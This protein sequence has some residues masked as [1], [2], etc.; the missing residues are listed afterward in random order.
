MIGAGKS[1]K[2]IAEELSI[3]YFTVKNHVNNLFIKLGMH[4]RAEAIHF[5]IRMK[6]TE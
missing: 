5:A 2:E 4:T 3:S 1:N 6:L